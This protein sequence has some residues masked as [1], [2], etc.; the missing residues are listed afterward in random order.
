MTGATAI[1]PDTEFL[2]R[3]M[4]AGGGDL[5]KC[6]QCA[7][8]SVACEL[9][10]DEEPFPRRQMIEAQW[11]LKD[12]LVADP[13]VWLCHN[14]GKCT[15]RCPRGARPGDVFGALR[16]ETIRHFAFPRFAGSLVANPRALPLLF[17]LPVLIFA[18]IVLWAP[19]PDPAPPF[20]FAGVFPV[21]VLEPLFFAISGFALLAFVVGIVRFARSLPGDSAALGYAGALGD[22][23]AHRRF[24]AC[25][26]PAMRTAHMLTLGGFAG[27]A[28][29]GTVT[30]VGTLAGILRTPLP[31]AGALKIFANLAAVAALAG[32]VLLL[33]RRLR[34]PG[35][36]YF[37]W[38]FLATLAG[39]VATGIASEILRLA[40]LRVM[41]AVYFVHLVLIVS[42]LL[43]A[44]YSKFAHLAYRTVAMA[45][46]RTF[47]GRS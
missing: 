36:T 33:A 4:A 32:V 28:V 24:A 34:K 21:N 42:L 19:R 11:G 46:S 8:C 13:A 35:G 17:L 38:F 10:G 22:I 25:D 2:G 6:Y 5:K 12:R 30:G 40:E 31:T 39:V 15:E 14:C 16:R 45:S 20:E 18:A 1:Q 43:Y 27:L 7:T 23:V 3:V 37:D 9:S 26:E 47:K 29:V 44:P 41:Y